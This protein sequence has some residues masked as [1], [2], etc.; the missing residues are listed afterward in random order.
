MKTVSAL[1]ICTL[2]LWSAG[3]NNLQAQSKAP[4][5]LYLEHFKSS[6]KRVLSVRVLSK[7]EKKYLPAAGLEVF[8]YISEISE[9]GLLGAIITTD[10]GTGTYTLSQEQVELAESRNIVQYFA[11]VKESETL[12]RKEA[13]MNIKNVNLEVTY[14]G[15]SIWAK[16]IY[17]HVFET[18][19][20]GNDIPQEDVEVKFLVERPLSPLPIKDVFTPG[21]D[22]GRTF[23]DINGNIALSFPGDLPGDADGNLQ[24]LIKIVENDD[25]GTVEV[26]DIKEWGIPTITNDLTLKRSLWASSANA[27]VSLLIFIN[28]LI[29]AVWGIIFYILFKIFHIRRLGKV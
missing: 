1:L 19:S 6:A 8:L 15:D 13:E 16:R 27:P 10:E 7:P 18:D 25:Y 23:T 11:V 21:D 3:L 28:S 14:F 24:I 2:T 20:A 29:A 17:V 12:R 26:A 9:K 5:R 22:K 4:V